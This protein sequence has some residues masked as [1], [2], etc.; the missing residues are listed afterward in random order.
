MPRTASDFFVGNNQQT[1]SNRFGYAIR[2]KRNQLGI[3]QT[4]LAKL[5]KLNRSYLSELERG[6]VGISLERAERVAKALGCALGDLIG[7]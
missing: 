3:S 2:E 6:L 5:A 7:Y 4:E 1:V